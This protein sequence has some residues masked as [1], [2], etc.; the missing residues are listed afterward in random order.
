MFAGL[1]C[2]NG[3]NDFNQTSESVRSQ[4]IALILY[5]FS[6]ADNIIFLYQGYV[7][8]S[9]EFISIHLVFLL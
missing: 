4:D 3:H 6:R 1:W 2:H 7:K 8:S 5:W 9:P